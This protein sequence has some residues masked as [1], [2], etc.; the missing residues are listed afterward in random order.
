MS[1]HH[2][3]GRT[4]H[5][6]QSFSSSTEKSIPAFSHNC[7][8]HCQLAK[9]SSCLNEIWDMVSQ[10]LLGAILL[11]PF[12]L[13]CNTLFFFFFCNNNNKILTHVPRTL[14][15]TMTNA[16]PQLPSTPSV[17]T[18]LL[19]SVLYSDY[20]CFEKHTTLLCLAHQGIKK[21]FS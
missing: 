4:M 21:Y 12:K 20:E 10:P 15:N 9:F 11:F 6:L 5:V 13:S 8:V 16:V 3:S 14:S 17:Y 7:I 19:P 1:L 2:V 18:H